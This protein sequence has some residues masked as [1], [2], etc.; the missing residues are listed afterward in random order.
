MSPLFASLHHAQCVSSASRK[1]APIDKAWVHAFPLSI[2][3]RVSP[4]RVAG[5]HLW[6]KLG[7]MLCLFPPGSA[8]VLADSR[9]STAQQ[10]LGPRFAS[11]HQTQ[12]VSSQSRDLAP[13]D[14]AFVHA[15]PLSSKLTASPSQVA[16]S[17]RRTR[18]RSTFCLSQP[19]SACLLPESPARTEGQDLV[20]RF[21]SLLQTQRSSLTSSRLAP[22]DKA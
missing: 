2:R 1:L 13:Q 6:T 9:A 12:L 19:G 22:Q 7:S 5:S 10:S 21:A 18:L 16:A 20:P 11:L 4:R 17:H 14:K 8:C 15:L 3:V